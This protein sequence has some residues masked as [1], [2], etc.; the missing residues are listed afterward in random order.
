MTEFTC[1]EDLRQVARRRVPRMFYDYVDTGSW[2][3]YTY[4]ANEAAFQRLEFR[5]RVAVD[6]T[7]RS[8]ATRMVGQAV[9]M[10]LAIAP[11]GLTGMVHPDGEILAAKAAQKAGVPFTLSTM[12]ICSIEAVAQ[13]TN[14]HP[15]WFQLYVMR[16]RKFVASLIRRAQPW[17]SRWIYRSL[18]NGTRTKKMACQRHPDPRCEMC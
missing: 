7:E 13:A 14:S 5:Q 8:T 18:A 9:S 17:W 12:S 6:I 1:I 15:F 10:P 3:E 2:T 11:T 16:D 4:R